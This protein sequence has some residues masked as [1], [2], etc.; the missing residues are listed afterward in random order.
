MIKYLFS[1]L[2]PVQANPNDQDAVIKS[3]NS[4]MSTMDAVDYPRES[5]EVVFCVCGSDKKDQ[6]Y[7]RTV[8]LIRVVNMKGQVKDAAQFMFDRSN[9]HVIIFAT[10]GTRFKKNDLNELAKK[11]DEKRN[12]SMILDKD[13]FSTRKLKVRIPNDVCNL[14]TYLILY[15]LLNRYEIVGRW[16]RF[17]RKEILRFL[18]KHDQFRLRDKIK[19][20]FKWFI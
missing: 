15:S 7:I 10:L 20:F 8:P 5:Y 9:G 18:Y 12:I 13:V 16:K 14:R 19:I 17:D 4:F 11:Y 3:V 2:V 6:R 1:I